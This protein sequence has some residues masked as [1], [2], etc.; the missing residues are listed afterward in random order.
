MGLLRNDSK[1][2]VNANNG[3]GLSSGGFNAILDQGSEF[4]GKL[5]FEGVV[6][7]DGL[8]KGEVFAPA[9]LVVGPTGKVIANI[10]VDIVTISGHVEG[11][12][13]AKTRVELQSTA[14]VKGNIFASSVVVEDGA[15]FDGKMTM[16]KGEPNGL[17][18]RSK[19]QLSQDD[20]VHA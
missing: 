15:I 17:A 18:E 13:V 4:E 20:E 19:N 7:I 6:R 10:N 1:S 9:H 16:S 12:I 8:F 3:A 5:S 14:H 11:D 2:T